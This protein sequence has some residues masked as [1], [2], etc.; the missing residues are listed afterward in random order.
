MSIDFRRKPTILGELVILRPVASADIPALRAGMADAETA[1]LTGSIHASSEASQLRWSTAELEETYSRWAAA[2]DRIVWSI[3]ERSSGAVVGES[4]LKDL[5]TTNRSCGFRIWI[6]GARNQGLGTEA[7]RLTLRHAFNDQGLHRVEL[8]VY[9]F[10]PRACH[11]YE[12]VGFV[13]E[14]VKRQALLFDDEW[15]DAHT[16]SILKHEW[17]A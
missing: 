8:A 7:T 2:D 6:S 14:G 17:D 4:V 13:Q 15:V 1:K 11:V 12:K 3:V 16:M 10:N 9:A 5:E